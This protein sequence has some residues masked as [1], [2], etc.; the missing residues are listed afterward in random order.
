MSDNIKMRSLNRHQAVATTEEA[1]YKVRERILAERT[2]NKLFDKYSGDFLPEGFE[3]ARILKI[4]VNRLYPKQ[5]EEFQEEH[6]IEEVAKLH[7]THYKQKRIKY[8]VRMHEYLTSQRQQEQS[9]PL[10]PYIP[11]QMG[12]S[13]NAMP[14]LTLT[15]RSQQRI[16]KPHLASVLG[17]HFQNSLKQGEI[18][19]E[20][21]GGSTFFQTEVIIRDDPQIANNRKTLGKATFSSPKQQ[22]QYSTTQRDKEESSLTRFI[23]ARE[24]LE[25]RTRERL[26]KLRNMLAKHLK[27]EQS[28]T[29]T[30]LEVIEERKH[31][32]AQRQE[33]LNKARL[34]AELIIKNKEDQSI[35]DYKALVQ[36]LTLCGGTYSSLSSTRKKIREQSPETKRQ[37]S[38]ERSKI[39]DSQILPSQVIYNSQ[40]TRLMLGTQKRSLHTTERLID[41]SVVQEIEKEH[42]EK[43]LRKY[44]ERRIKYDKARKDNDEARSYNVLH[45]REKSRIKLEHIRVMEKQT[46]KSI[47]FKRAELQRQ[48]IKRQE[49]LTEARSANALANTLKRESTKLK[50]LDY[51][52]NYQS[53]CE[54]QKQKQTRIY[55]KHENLRQ[56]LDLIK[57]NRERIITDAYM[58]NFEKR[59]YLEQKQ[60]YSNPYEDEIHLV[61]YGGG[62]KK[63]KSLVRSMI[64]E[65]SKKKYINELAGETGTPPGT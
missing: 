57:V 47:E 55:S 16:S 26:F 65:M 7:H 2:F 30:R 46:A 38:T 13:R 9:S 54:K 33:K 12:A 53:E 59:A 6:S 24:S 1:T 39:Q 27:Q 62:S 20:N 51:R 52:E 45:K 48:D 8:L 5:L 25:L 43:A 21:Q 22:C 34:R 60:R 37:H 35:R 15:R 31:K 29:E 50:M 58:S 61:Q 49:H 36:D 14:A 63:S 23:R 4:D 17:T 18:T 40:D 19:V 64:M 3:L 41:K 32:S 56:S 10:S 28:A 11:V 42:V 44:L